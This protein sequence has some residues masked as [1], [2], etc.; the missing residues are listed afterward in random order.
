MNAQKIQAAA[1]GY[2]VVGV[3]LVTAAFGMNAPTWVKILSLFSGVLGVA[4]RAINP[5][6]PAYGVVTAAKTATDAVLEKQGVTPTD[7]SK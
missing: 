4:G 2:L 5:K 6:D 7:S 3:P 1:V